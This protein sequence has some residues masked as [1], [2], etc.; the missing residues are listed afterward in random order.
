MQ[1]MGRHCLVTG[2]AG[3]IGSHLV[4]LLL[5]K[6]ASV[7]A[8][9]DLSVGSETNLQQATKNPAF[10]FRKLDI[11]DQLT[12]TDVMK[13]VDAVFHLATQSVRL[14]LC[15][16][17]RVHDV[18]INGT[19]NV[20][21][22]AASAGV[23]KF[24]YCSSSEV[25][26]TAGAVPMAEK[27]DYAPETIY[28]ASKL[29]GEYYTQVFERSGWLNTV[30]A[31]P[32]NNYGPRAHYHG[33]AGELI[34]RMILQALLNEP[35]TIYGNGEQTRDFT[36]VKETCAYLIRLVENENCRGEILNVCRGQEVSVNE[37]ASKILKHTKSESTVQRLGS[38]RSDVLRLWGDPTA[39]KNKLGDSPSLSIDEGLK[40]TVDWYRENVPLNEFTR[41]AL[42]AEAWRE[43][44]KEEWL[45]QVQSNL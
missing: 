30:I 19:Y 17:S 7:T 10:R 24:L 16:P 36:Y 33:L 44:P 20:L 43:S 18:N 15:R 3:F 39:L 23:K 42:T 40:M 34:P 4:D 37:I 14:S 27:Y 32:H 35:L 5:E 31:R 2:G 9:D 38:R 28:G 41:K 45:E 22:A 1:L 12:L 6:G 11:L 25:N 8:I 29:A 26:G 13:N 21:T